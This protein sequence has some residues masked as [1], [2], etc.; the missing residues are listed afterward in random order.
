MIG[1]KYMFP[2]FEND[3]M[4]K[5]RAL[6]RETALLNEKKAETMNEIQQLVHMV[7]RRPTYYKTPTQRDQLST[8]IWKHIDAYTAFTNSIRGS[9]YKY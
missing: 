5:Y 7:I 3:Y 8:K 1:R 9:H 2:Q 6:A 4:Q